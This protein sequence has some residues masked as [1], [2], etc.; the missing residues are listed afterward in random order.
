MPEMKE[1]RLSLEKG[2]YE[3]L[4]KLFGQGE[5][6]LVCLHGGPGGGHD[7][8]LRFG[9]LAEDG[10]QVLLYDQL[11]SGKSGVPDDVPPWTVARFVEE[12]EEIRTAFNL[13]RI[14]LM[15]QSWGG[16]LA[17]QYALDHP[18]ALK[19]LII[20]NSATGMI[21]VMSAIRQL[22]LGIPHQARRDLFR[23]QAGPEKDPTKLV[24]A[25]VEFYAR[26]MRR[27]IPF[28]PEKSIRE[29]NEEIMPLFEELGAA[30]AFLGLWG[31]DPTTCTGPLLDWD[32]S[33]RLHEIVVPT[34]IVC[35]WYDEIPPDLHFKLAERIP[36]NEFVIFGN[37]SHLL[38][39]EKDADAYL[40]LIR[41][42]VHRVIV[43]Q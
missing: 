19:S 1:G 6:T 28:D 24:N 42:F 33:D 41:D 39:H 32:V 12:L 14:H 43:R 30:P 3:I 29:F 22:Q 27:T 5:E 40:A 17:M 10:L 23:A 35:G 8:L 18:D 7:Y 36:D 16:M 21:E 15:G 9:E 13:G 38:T 34:L 25:S 26:N 20:S 2:N 37:A 11:G 4:Y 31:P